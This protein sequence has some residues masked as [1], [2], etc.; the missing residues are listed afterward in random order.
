MS[1]ELYQ[2]IKEL[3]GIIEKASNDSEKLEMQHT[4][5]VYLMSILSAQE[6]KLVELESTINVIIEDKMNKPIE[7]A[8]KTLISSI[9]NKQEKEK[10]DLSYTDR[11]I[12]EA[13]Y[14]LDCS[15][16]FSASNHITKY[17]NALSGAISQI[18]RYINN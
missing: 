4:I 10:L 2:R 12:E 14:S 7:D 16:A 11:L 13:K 5:I 17:L 15:P 18:Q 6:R 9:A 1:N 8:V 3:S